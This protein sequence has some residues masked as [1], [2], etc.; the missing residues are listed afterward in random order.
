MEADQGTRAHINNNARPTLSGAQVQ[1][2]LLNI[3][4]PMCDVWVW[5]ADNAAGL[6]VREGVPYKSRPQSS[7]GSERPTAVPEWTPSSG[8]A[9]ADHRN[10]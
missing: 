5:Q 8:M 2:G 1:N 7:C 6:Q 9:R 4:R 10:I 3:S